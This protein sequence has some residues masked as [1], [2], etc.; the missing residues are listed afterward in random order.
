MP[1]MVD[2][3]G[4]VGQEEE[5]SVVTTMLFVT[6][7]AVGGS[8]SGGIYTVV[9]KMCLFPLLL[10]PCALSRSGIKRIC[11]R[12]HPTAANLVAE[13]VGGQQGGL[14]HGGI[15]VHSH[16]ISC[17]FLLLL[18]VQRLLIKF[19]R[20]ESHKCTQLVLPLDFYTF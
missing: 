14:P 8:K 6:P 11:W 19:N 17:F 10:L 2:S 16:G 7:V 5:S 4:L 3:E 15:V 13:I 12:S 18:K 1:S 9:V 20:M